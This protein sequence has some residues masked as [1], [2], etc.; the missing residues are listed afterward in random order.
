MSNPKIFQQNTDAAFPQLN[1][2]NSLLKV[3]NVIY[4]FFFFLNYNLPIQT[5]QSITIYAIDDLI[6]SELDSHHL[7]SYSTIYMYNVYMNN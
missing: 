1:Q 5:Y 2:R 6:L 3:K 4:Q 7:C